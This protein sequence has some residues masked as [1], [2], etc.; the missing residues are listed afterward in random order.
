MENLLLFIFTNDLTKVLLQSK[1]KVYI[2]RINGICGKVE[3]YDPSPGC[4]A[5]RETYDETGYTR[6]DFSAFGKLI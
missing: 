2:P 5:L 6:E 4:A 1:P 3:P